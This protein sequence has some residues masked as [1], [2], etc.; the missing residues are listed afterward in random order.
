VKPP[1]PIYLALLSALLL[2]ALSITAAPVRARNEIVSDEIP[3]PMPMVDLS[4]SDDLTIFLLFGT[5]TSNPNN[6]GLTDMAM[7]VAVHRS[8]GAAAMLSIPRDLWV[9]VPEFGMRKL[10]TAYYLGET[11]QVEGG[12]LRLLKDT[13]RYNLGIEPDYYA[14]V[15]FD[16]FMRLIDAVGGVDLSVDCVIRDWILKEPHLDKHDPDNYELFT[17][18]IGINH[19]DSHHALWYVRSRRTSTDIDLGRR[20]QDV[21]RALWR[22][23]RSRDMLSELPSLW[24][25]VSA[26][27]D[28]DL[29]LPDLL[30][31]V[32]FAM[33]IEADRIVPFRFKIGEHLR[34]ALSP[35]PQYAA[36]LAPN[37]DAVIGLMQQFVAPPTRNQ[38]ARSNL[39]VEI[40]NAS[41]VRDL[42]FVAA[43]RLAQEGFVPVVVIEPTHYRNYTSIYDYTGQTKNSSVPSLQRVLRVNDE[44]VIVEPDPNRTADYKIYLGNSY[45]YWS[46][47]RDVIQPSDAFENRNA[48]TA[49]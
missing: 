22:K 43:D 35:A 4:R 18:P 26:V 7:L 46:C 21:M 8:S 20:Q 15:N 24:D 5:A 32:P 16:G 31:M 30:G 29:S 17:L 25:Q 28:T 39:V 2:T 42:Q 12:G 11:H 37:R 36:I 33:N 44:G 45:S 19:L 38:I 34:N 13:V 1:Y 9:N 10:T 27:V 47:T 40:V 49:P 3:E 41:G 23:I 14:H 48:A 6:P